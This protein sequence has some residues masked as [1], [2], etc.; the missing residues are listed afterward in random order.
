LGSAP[1]I[2]SI[3]R[4]FFSTNRVGMLRTEKRFEVM[5]FSST[6]IFAIRTLPA[7]SIA[8]ES[9]MGVTNRQG[10]HHGAQRSRSTGKGDCSTSAENVASV[11]TTVP[12]ETDRRVLHR[13]HTGSSPCLIFSSGTRLLAPQSGHL[14]SCG[15][16]T[17]LMLKTLHSQLQ[18][19]VLASDDVQIY[20]TQAGQMKG[21]IRN[22]LL[23]PAFSMTVSGQMPL[24]SNH[25]YPATSC[26]PVQAYSLAMYR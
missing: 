21:S 6:F 26:L 19:G 1:T 22:V 3:S 14:M 5:G 20:R 24:G 9:M 7:I 25:P 18:E 13:P 16:A 17:F 10:P 11:T 4:P 15:S 12:C 23:S 8:R 2:R